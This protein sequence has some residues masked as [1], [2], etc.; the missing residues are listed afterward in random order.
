VKTNRPLFPTPVGPYN[1][2]FTDS[3]FEIEEKN[4]PHKRPRSKATKRRAIKIKQERRLH[5]R[6]GVSVFKKA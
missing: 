4:M 6:G 1:N 3:S 2:F 5:K